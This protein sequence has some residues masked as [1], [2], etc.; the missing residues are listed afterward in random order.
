MY[1]NAVFIAPSSLKNVIKEILIVIFVNK[2][3]FF[4]NVTFF[5]LVDLLSVNYVVKNKF[6][7]TKVHKS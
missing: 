7:F 4:R 3:L 5:L 2:N 1:M 6:T